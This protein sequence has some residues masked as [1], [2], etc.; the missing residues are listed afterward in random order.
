MG[1][2]RVALDVEIP[3]DVSYIEGVVELAAKRCRELRVPARK[4]SLNLRVALTEALSN[5]ILRGNG[6]SHEKVVR[7]RAT[8]TKEAIVFDIFDQGAGFDLA[9]EKR[10][11][12]TSPENLLSE[13]GRG[14]FLMRKLM[15]E[16]E[17]L[18]DGGNTVRLTLRR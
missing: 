16:V 12:P 13:E 7:I 6:S 9:R 15:D 17:Q 11:D 4:C 2:S 1:R 10:R 3:S 8:V 14:I 18:E 5:A